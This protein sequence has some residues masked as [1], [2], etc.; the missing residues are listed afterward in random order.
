MK[1]K[2]F[3]LLTLILWLPFGLKAQLSYDYKSL[4]MEDWVNNTWRNSSRI[5]NDYDTRGNLTTS[6]QED[7]DTIKGVWSFYGKTTNQY[8]SNDQLI[9]VTSAEWSTLA[10]TWKDYSISS[11]T[12]NADGTTKESLSKYWDDDEKAWIDGSKTTFTYNAAKKVLTETYQ[13]NMGMGWMDFSKTICTYNSNNV[14]TKE[15][16]QGINWMTQKLEDQRQVLYEYHA[17]GTELR[18]T[19]QKKDEL[20]GN[21][22]DDHRSSYTYITVNNTRVVGTMLDENFN[23]TLWVPE[24]RSTLSYNSDGTIKEELFELWNPDLNAWENYWKHMASYMRGKIHQIIA[25]EWNKDSRSWV[26][27]TRSTFG[28]LSTGLDRLSMEDAFLGN[29]Y[30]NPFTG[31]VLIEIQAGGTVNYMVFNSSGQLV[32]SAVSTGHRATLNLQSLGK[33]TYYLKATSGNKEQI[34]KLVKIR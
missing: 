4:L 17:D 2:F 7:W 11:Y 10:N 24:E 12:L 16:Y 9:Q 34:V 30:P 1:T 21:W 27:Y 31:K 5:I 32:H 13:M 15:I 25:Q 8:N 19:T 18:N 22:V 28:Y 20:S 33:G 23:N 3:L 6:T 29:V 14:L 26:N